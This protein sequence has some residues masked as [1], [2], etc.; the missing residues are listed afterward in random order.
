[1]TP[2]FLNWQENRAVPVPVML[3]KQ[4]S[5]RENV[6]R[7]RQM[8]VFHGTGSRIFLIIST[9]SWQ[10]PNFI[11]ITRMRTILSLTFDRF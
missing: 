5:A 9:R 3:T 8:K 10:V 1:L 4:A 7:K 2:L 6:W 11:I